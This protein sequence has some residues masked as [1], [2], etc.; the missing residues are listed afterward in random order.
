MKHE[1]N[2]PCVVCGDSRSILRHEIDYSAYGYLGHFAV[3]E[4]VGCGLLFNSPRLSDP[5]IFEL[6][7]GNY[8]VFQ[9]RE[10]DAVA[11]VAGLLQ[12]TV[13][14][15]MPHVRDKQVLEV[16]CAK[17]FLLAMLRDQG[18]QVEGV[19]LSAAAASHARDRFGLSVFEGTL[20]SY[21]ARPG[22][23]AHPVV[24]TTDVIEHVLDLDAFVR[25]LSL[26]VAPG[27]V[28]VVGTPNADSDHRHA[29]GSRW[30]G[31]N[32][33]HIYLL[34]Q[35]NLS[36]LLARHGFDVLQAY[37]FTNDDPPPLVAPSRWKG[38]VKA[39]LG[40]SGVLGTVRSARHAAL[41]LVDALVSPT[42]ALM[43]AA[44]HA[45]PDAGYA[46]TADGRHARSLACR[47]DNLVLIARRREGA[48]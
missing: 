33:F 32:P 13:G 48:D 31:F 43:A 9:E 29:H 22:H 47:G 8:Y 1:V 15:A 27:G 28:L 39:A 38:W 41:S 18:W 35:A 16:G 11:R 20:E 5:E 6:Y 44:A 34:S 2:V 21:V 17:G 37:S 36:S 25:G 45:F 24:V 46:E 12:R 19:E 42:P 26:A 14:V 10:R 30:L 23:Q 4:C 7:D 40:K 3:R